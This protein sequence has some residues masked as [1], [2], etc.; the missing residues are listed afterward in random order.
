MTLPEKLDRLKS[1]KIARLLG[2]LD[3]HA[4]RAIELP[5]AQPQQQKIFPELSPAD[6]GP[7]KPIAPTAPG[8]VPLSRF[9]PDAVRVMNMEGGCSLR[10]VALP[11]PGAP[12]SASSQPLT[13]MEQCRFPMHSRLSAPVEAMARAAQALLSHEPAA[14]PLD[15]LNAEDILFVDIETTGLMGSAGIYPFLIGIGRIDLPGRA[16]IVEQLFM[17]DFDQERAQLAALAERI[18]AARAIVTFNGRTFDIPLLRNR[19]IFHRM[20]RRVFEL[21][22][23]DLL[24]PARRFWRKRFAS[25][26]L[27]SLEAE[28]FSLRREGDV[29]GELIPAIYQEYV[30]GQSPENIVPVLTHNVQDVVSMA[31]LLL[32]MGGVLEAGENLPDGCGH[33]LMGLAKLLHKRGDRERAVACRERAVGDLVEPDL[34]FKAMMDLGWDYKRMER[35]DDALETFASAARMAPPDLALAAHEERA[36]IFEHKK[37]DF[38]AAI[39]AVDDAL[40]LLQHHRELMRYTGSASEDQWTE[41]RE[42]LTRRKDRLAKKF[43]RQACPPKAAR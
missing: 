38:D 28:L 8:E 30:R 5:S 18:A 9:F 2:A 31:G 20:N 12:L 17:E 29:P 13:A 24:H 43:E 6:P 32:L 37:A 7:A 39:R 40:N 3:G 36:K 27:Q 26:S 19:M 33:E 23:A 11:L 14:G 4:C 10:R 15:P 25:C 22:H 1:D 16:F 35:W 42:I 41:W 34:Q 21:P